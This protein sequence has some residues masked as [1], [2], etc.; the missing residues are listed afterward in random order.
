MP[1]KK[2]DHYTEWTPEKAADFLELIAQGHTATHAAE[3]C[4][5]SRSAAYKHRESDKLFA[6]AWKDAEA[7]GT[8]VLEEEA[9]RRAKQGVLEP[10]YQGGSKVGTI[11]KYSDTLLIFLLKARK[12]E[13][14]RE[15]A[16]V[17]HEG[18]I[19]VDDASMNDEQR[20][21]RIA[22]ILDEARRRAGGGS[23]E[24]PAAPDG[25]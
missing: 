21:L 15:N 25:G 17:K 23:G 22:A 14:Y 19:T 9:F 18:G 1:R 8:E 10:V 11:R 5:V 4:R 24:A 12:P 2:R 3:Q 7:A 13:T 20:A 6:A 16:T